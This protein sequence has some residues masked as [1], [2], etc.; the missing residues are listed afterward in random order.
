[1]HWKMIVIIATLSAVFIPSTAHAQEIPEY[2]SP[3]VLEHQ[4]ELEE[5]FKPYLE[6]KLL[7]EKQELLQELDWYIGEIDGIKGPLTKNATEKFA[8]AAELDST[9]PETII[10]AASHE[11]APQAPAP[12]PPTPVPSTPSTAN[13]ASPAPA[14]GSSPS[15]SG[16]RLIIADCESGNHL[17]NGRAARGSYN[18]N[19]INQQGSSASGAFQ[20]ID[21]TWRWVAHDMLGYTQYPTARSAPPYVQI[22]AFDWLWANGGKQHW[23]PSSSCWSGLL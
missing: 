9:D 15:L 8:E 11:D 2:I 1:M 23:S 4:E 3:Y 6:E 19:S 13:S 14:Q 12:P 22:E 20:F 21:S 17:A 5:A 10:E 18:W 16:H 7:I